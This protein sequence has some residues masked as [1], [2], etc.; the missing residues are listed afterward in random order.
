MD[1]NF[2]P[3]DLAF[4]DEVRAFINEAFDDEMRDKLAQS[5]NHHLDKA[6]QVR[7]LK[8]LGEKGWM[9]P[10]WPVEHGGTGWSLSKTGIRHN[11]NC[12]YYDAAKACQATEG[13]PCKVCKG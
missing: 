13:T 5:K 8:R 1:L 9:A 3:E 4:G 11:A 7:W 6:S 2:S 10:D 12:R